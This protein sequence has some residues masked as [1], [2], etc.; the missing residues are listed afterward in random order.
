MCSPNFTVAGSTTWNVL[1]Q[2]KVCA[3][4]KRG[5]AGAVHAPGHTRASM[6]CAVYH[7]EKH[8]NI[9]LAMLCAWHGL[10]CGG[11]RT[12]TGLACDMR[13]YECPQEDADERISRLGVFLD[14]SP[15]EEE[16]PEFLINAVFEIA[17]ENKDPSF[18]ETRPLFHTF[19]RESADWGFRELVFTAVPFHR[20]PSVLY[21]TSRLST[22]G[23]VRRGPVNH[24]A[25]CTWR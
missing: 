19:C 9:E 7:Q 1:L 18:N 2:L 15:M 24:V 10:I 21:C 12:R 3:R 23:S 22:T 11:D 5:H 25:C 17:A 13:I 6:H 14:S 16:N 4:H 8:A 20:L